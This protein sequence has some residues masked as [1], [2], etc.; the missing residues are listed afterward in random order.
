M[1]CKTVCFILKTLDAQK[2]A[3]NCRLPI[4]E[5]SRYH[6]VF[7][8]CIVS[9]RSWNLYH[10]HWLINLVNIDHPFNYFQ[11]SRYI[12]CLSGYLFVCLYPALKRVNRSGPNLVWDFTWPREGLWMFLYYMVQRDDAQGFEPQF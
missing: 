6:G 11:L 10:T 1:Q 4:P 2:I 12:L 3:S 9:Y 5:F 7:P 8:G